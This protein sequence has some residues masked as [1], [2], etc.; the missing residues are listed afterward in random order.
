MKAAMYYTN[1]D[2]RVEEIPMPDIQSGEILMRVKSSGLCGSDLM[3]WYRL[4]KAPLVL[5]HEVAGEIVKVGKSVNNFKEGDRIVTTHHVPCNSCYYCLT[6]RHTVCPSIKSTHFDPG[7]F[8]EYLRIP[9]V[10]ELS[11]LMK[12]FHTMK[13]PL[14]NRLDVL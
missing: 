11:C 14:L 1:N 13:G 10:K 12:L 6:D 3:E 2:I 9:E 8:S 4:P 7:G 5:G